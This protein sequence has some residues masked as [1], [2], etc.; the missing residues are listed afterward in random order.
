MLSVMGPGGTPGVLV[1]V[2]AVG[3][4]VTEDDA[5]GAGGGGLVCAQA[6]AKAPTAITLN[7]VRVTS[8]SLPNERR[9]VFIEYLNHAITAKSR[10][11]GLRLSHRRQRPVR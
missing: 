6:A 8:V 7:Q 3:R 4:G 10:D 9:Y 2:A 11:V 1:S 5:D